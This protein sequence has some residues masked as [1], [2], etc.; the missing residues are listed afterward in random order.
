MLFLVAA[1]CVCTIIN[2]CMHIKLKKDI[3]NVNEYLKICDGKLSGKQASLDEIVKQVN[4]LSL[5]SSI[6]IS[7]LSDDIVYQSK[8]VKI[9]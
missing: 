3:D 4:H 7:K 6:A 9:H 2:Y 5:L 1:I 8:I